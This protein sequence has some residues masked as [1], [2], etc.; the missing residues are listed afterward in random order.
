MLRRGLTALLASLLLLPSTILGGGEGCI[1]SGLAGARSPAGSPAHDHAQHG[2]SSGH[3]SHRGDTDALV[4]ETDATS[5][6]GVPNAPM[7][8][9]L[10]M[11]CGSAVAA[12]A[13]VAIEQPTHAAAGMPTDVASPPDSPTLG[14]EPPPP[15]A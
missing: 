5:P 4:D 13:V 6:V 12:A 2:R 15:R 9:I 8:C 3:T 1:V 10:V 14:L 7:P 11:G